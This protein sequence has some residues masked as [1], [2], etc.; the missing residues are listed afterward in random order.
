MIQLNSRYLGS[1]PEY[2]NL[3]VGFVVI[4]IFGTGEDGWREKEWVKFR[5]VDGEKATTLV[6]RARG[7][8]VFV[9]EI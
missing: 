2:E 3:E 1:L 7:G 8:I 9:E 5:E 4:G 6:H